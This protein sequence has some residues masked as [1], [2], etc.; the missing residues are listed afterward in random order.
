MDADSNQLL[1]TEDGDRYP[2]EIRYHNQ[3]GSRHGQLSCASSDGATS[4]EL[5]SNAS[6]LDGAFLDGA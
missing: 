2:L 1:T 5:F 4:V 3:M 6:F